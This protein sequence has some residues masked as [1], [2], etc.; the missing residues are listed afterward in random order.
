MIICKHINH[1]ILCLLFAGA[2]HSL[3]AQAGVSGK[4]GQVEL[5]DLSGNGIHLES[6]AGKAE[7]FVFL[8]PECPLS[9]NYTLTLNKLYDKYAGKIQFAGIVPGSSYGATEVRK[10]VAEYAIRFPVYLDPEKSLV[11]LLGAGITPE[12]F[13][14]N[15]E[16]L[17]YSGAIDNWAVSLGKQRQVVTEHYLEDAIQHYLQGQP[18]TVK[19]AQAVGCRIDTF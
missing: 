9:R 1:V 10:F 8:A 4:P 11:S 3:F 17:L 5:T 13:L 12:A 18:L 6:G 15:G 16:N 19:H 14:I 2:H 7:L